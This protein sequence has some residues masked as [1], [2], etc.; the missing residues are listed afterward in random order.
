ML[1]DLRVAAGFP[2]LTAAAEKL[3]R[4]KGSLSRIENGFVTLPPR[5]LPVI[6]DVYGVS[7]HSVRETILAVTAEIR[8]EKRGW[9]VEHSDVLAPSYVDLIRLEAGASRIRT[10]E[11]QLVPGLLQTPD[12]A[13]AA[14]APGRE[15][16][17]EDD[18]DQFIAIRTARQAV[19][20]RRSPVVF[21]AVLNEAIF[22]RNI[23]GTEVM[24][25]Q[26]ERL[27]ELA[28]LSHVKLQV[29]PFSVGAHAGIPASFTLL[30]LAQPAVDFVQI[31]LMASDMYVE[32]DLDV[33]QYVW[34]FDELCRTALN[35]VDSISMINGFV[36]NLRA[37]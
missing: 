3:G 27:V 5:D 8:Q 7:D 13:R 6:F 22:H 26:L 2:S 9:W 21:H 31:E 30:S 11:I 28:E 37:N 33:G 16:S 36:K 20:K 4:S 17:S 25:E 1:A 32:E 35:P 14:I 23:G 24:G 15:W 12:Y 29:L 19:L 34:T 18:L 10:Y